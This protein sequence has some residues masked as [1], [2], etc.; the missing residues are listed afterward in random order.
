MP[1]SAWVLGRL[2]PAE[3]S[4][5]QQLCGRLATEPDAAF[6]HAEL[7]DFLRG[8]SRQQFTSALA[9]APAA[10][11]ELERLN[12][13][14][15]MIEQLAHLLDVAPPDWTRQVPPLAHP[16]FGTDLQS[17]RLHLLVRALPSF[18]RRNVFVDTSIGGRV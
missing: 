16:V 18:R 7:N 11:I 13:L 4:T 12:Y 3:E 2:L 14:A 9:V 17:L 1:V 6:A 8:L 15:A 10:N 5:F